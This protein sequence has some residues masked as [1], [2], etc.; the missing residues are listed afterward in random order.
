MF[1]LDPNDDDDDDDTDFDPEKEEDPVD[2]SKIHS[3]FD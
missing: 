1:I 3:S 2:V